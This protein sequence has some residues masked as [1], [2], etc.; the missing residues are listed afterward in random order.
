MFHTIHF[1]SNTKKICYIKIQFIL[2][3][4]MEVIIKIK[5]YKIKKNYNYI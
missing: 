4:M 5:K 3:N 1:V 2:Y